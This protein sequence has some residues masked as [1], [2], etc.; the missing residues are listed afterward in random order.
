M[1]GNIVNF[2][3]KKY[4]VDYHREKMERCGAEYVDCLVSDGIAWM[5][6]KGILYTEYDEAT[7]KWT[8]EW[9]DGAAS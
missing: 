7:G 9:L 6:T 2:R 4:G 5:T 8:R 3:P 1:S